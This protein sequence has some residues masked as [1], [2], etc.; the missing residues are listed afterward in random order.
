VLPFTLYKISRN[1]LKSWPFFT[2][3]TSYIQ[4]LCFYFV[5]L[6]WHPCITLLRI[7]FVWNTMLSR[8]V[9]L[10][11]CCKGK[12]CLCLQRYRDP[13]FLKIKVQQSL[14][15]V[16]GRLPAMQHYIPDKRNSLYENIKTRIFIVAKRITK[17]NKV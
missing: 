2:W 14:R 9:I 6:P 10:S 5:N 4:V 7:S 1:L 15:N 8:W 13:K 16:V 11:G 12:Q 17:H 3:D